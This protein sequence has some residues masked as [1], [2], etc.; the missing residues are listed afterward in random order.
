MMQIAIE[1]LAGRCYATQ[2]S[3]PTQA[4]WP[5]EPARVFSALVATVHR[6]QPSDRAAARAWLGW[7]ERLPPPTIYAVPEPRSLKAPRTHCVRPVIARNARLNTE[8]IN[9]RTDTIY[10]TS[11]P[12]S[13]PV[14]LVRYEADLASEDRPIVERLLSAVAYLGS[15]ESL[16]HVRLSAENPHPLHIAFSPHEEGDRRFGVPT[17]GRLAHLD[18]AFSDLQR[19]DRK[20]WEPRALR[21]ARLANYRVES[22]AASP[23]ISD[24]DMG[25]MIPLRF[26]HR[27]G[28]RYGPQLD[29]WRFSQG[30][31]G[32]RRAYLARVGDNAPP[33]LTGHDAPGVPTARPHVAFVPLAEVGFPHARSVLRGVALV[34]PRDLSAELRARALRAINLHDVT[35]G[36]SKWPVEVDRDAPLSSLRPHRY[37]AK[38][39]TWITATPIALPRYPRR[40]ESV[41]AILSRVAAHAGLP[42][43]A[44]IQT[45]Q[46][47]FLEGAYPIFAYRNNLPDRPYL[48]HARIRFTNLVGGPVLLGRHRHAGYGLCLPSSAEAMTA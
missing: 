38:S 30:V 4:D 8:V 3:D 44:E 25:E 9:P 36:G 29:L 45:A 18:A 15:S 14:M 32:V 48:V 17:A 33:E 11:T 16:V 6:L 46:A 31:D 34:L 47:P 23:K 5:I 20:S 12:L 1:F 27:D 2:W 37:Q 7:L 40:D 35:I 39:Q 22:T 24:S 19:P 28:H 42:E 10:L 26:L 21:A 13:D 41:F 43:P